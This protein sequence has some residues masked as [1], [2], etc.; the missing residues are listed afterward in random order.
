ME[1]KNLEKNFKCK[2]CNY[3]TKTRGNLKNH[4]RTKKHKN[5]KNKIIKIETECVYCCFK[6]VSKSKMYIHI[7]SEKHKYRSQVKK[8]KLE[9]KCKLCDKKANG[10]DFGGFSLCDKCCIYKIRNYKL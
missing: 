4:F 10:D 6:Y 2:I 8:I 1:Y 3:S 9:D 5:K 7:S